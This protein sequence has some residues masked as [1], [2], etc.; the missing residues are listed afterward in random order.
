MSDDAADEGKAISTLMSVLKPLEPEART[1][2]IEFVLKRLAITLNS[3]APSQSTTGPMAKNAPSLPEVQFEPEPRVSESPTDIRSF[4]DLKRPSTVNE[5][6]AVV[7]FYLAH[8][9]SPPEQRDYLIADDIKPYFIQA[10]FELPTA[11]PRITL[12]N[13]KNAGYLNGLGDGQFRLNS[14]GYNLV[15]HKLPAQDVGVKKRA[16]KKKAK[17][18]KPNKARR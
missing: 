17:K 18:S 6:V 11:P 9:A 14:V 2:V 13:A 15:A 12:S 7:A 16:T 3:S 4:A 1:H 8:L 10:D 5:K